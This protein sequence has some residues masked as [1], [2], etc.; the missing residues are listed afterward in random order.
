LL[1]SRLPQ[2]AVEEYFTSSGALPVPIYWIGANRS[3]K[4]A[5]FTWYP[6]NTTV[7][8]VP[9]DDPYVHWNWFYPSR[10]VL[11]FHCGLA[12]WGNTV[13]R[14]TAGPGARV[15]SDCTAGCC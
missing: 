7:Q 9:N 14:P 6:V 15:L 3:T 4:S 12:R 1:F 11:E 13:D 5:P 2:L 8:V 10:R